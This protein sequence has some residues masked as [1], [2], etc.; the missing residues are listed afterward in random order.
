MSAA[1][2]TRGKAGFWDRL[3]GLAGRVGRSGSPRGTMPSYEVTDL[4]ARAR[5]AGPR[6]SALDAVMGEDW[7]IVEA[8]R[9]GRAPVVR[10]GIAAAHR[11]DVARHGGGGGGMPGGKPQ[12]VVK[13]IRQGGASDLRGLRAQMAYLSRQGEEPLQR[14]ERYMGVEID[15]EQ[16]GLLEQAWRMPEAGREGAADRTTH[17]IVSFPEGTPVGAAERAGRDWAEELFGSGLYGGDS[18]DYYTAFHTDR[19]HPHMHVVVHR[20][21]LEHGEWLKVSLRSDIHYDRMREVLVDVAARQGIELEATPRLARGLHDRVAP[22]AEYRR[23]GAARRE[24]V[25]PEHSPETALRAAAGLVHHAR[26]LEMEARTLELTDPAQAE[27]LRAAGLHLGEGRALTPAVWGLPEPPARTGAP[28]EILENVARMDRTLPG[29]GDPVERVRFMREVAELK[30]ETAPTLGAQGR[31][32]EAYTRPDESGRYDGLAGPDVS[33]VVA[34]P[35]ELRVAAIAK[36]YGVDKAAT[37]A[38]F[39]GGVP[40][41]GLA[42]DFA[43]SERLERRAAVAALGRPAETEET[44]RRALDQM[45]REIGEVHAVARAG[46]VPLRGVTLAG[47]QAQEAE[48]RA[49][50]RARADRA[51]REREVREETERTAR[52]EA[53]PIWQAVQAER[54]AERAEAERRAEAQRQRDRENAERSRRE[55]DGGGLGL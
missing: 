36:R 33:R 14:S 1:D 16:A 10:A 24:P 31:G 7:A 51:R 4:L 26:G 19:A 30:A 22:D 44:E 5:V 20:R 8:G 55:R 50:E 6:M 27:R 52:R 25:A 9:A 49:E 2:T 53:D 29:I 21:G 34:R 28:A 41:A 17:F 45:H 15:A 3:R 37:R 11:R 35:A 32:L 18:F 48:T 38:R 54:A 12:A 23:A 47:I 13:M 40:S 39:A 46:H 42:R 43:L